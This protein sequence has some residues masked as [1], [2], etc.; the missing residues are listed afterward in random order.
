MP[1]TPEEI[2]FGNADLRCTICNAKIGAC[3]CWVKCECGWSYE[4]G[5]KC[6]NSLHEVTDCA[7]QL[8]TDVAASIIEHMKKMYPEPMKYA[9]GGFRKTLRGAIDDGVSRLLVEWMVASE[10]TRKAN[11]GNRLQ[12]MAMK[13]DS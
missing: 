4:K 1:R 13:G 6:R 3:D 10:E 7:K 9:S 12:I 11:A 8:A 2:I 5:T